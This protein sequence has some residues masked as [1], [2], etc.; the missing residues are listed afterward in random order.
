MGDGELAEFK[1]LRPRS[2]A[3][4]RLYFGLCRVIAE[5]QDPPRDADSIDCELRIRAGHFDVMYVGEYEV[6]VPK[7]IAFDK[8]RQTSGRHISRK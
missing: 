7:R 5:N 8:M 6:R 4:H 1:V 2:V 3:W